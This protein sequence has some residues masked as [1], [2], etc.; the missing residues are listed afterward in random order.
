MDGGGLSHYV[1]TSR[2]SKAGVSIWIWR[3]ELLL[4][5]SAMLA[6]LTGLISGDR[7]VELRQ[8]ERSAVAVGA[9]ADF[10][11]QTTDSSARIATSPIP[12]AFTRSAG[13]ARA[14]PA[15][16]RA[17]PQAAPVDERRLE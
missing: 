5:L 1:P 13:P 12:P 4:F 14:F 7:A 17:L 16:A 6:G 9:A 8:V 11:G 10:A 2:R 15:A 3:L